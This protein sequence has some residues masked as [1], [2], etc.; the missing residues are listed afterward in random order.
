MYY[1]QYSMGQ[2]KRDVTPL[3]THWCYVFL[4]LTHQSVDYNIWRP[5]Q[6]GWYVVDNILKCILLKENVYISIQILLKFVP[7]GPIDNSI[8]SSNGLSPNNQQAIYWINEGSISSQIHLCVT[9]LNTLRPRQDGRLFG[10]WHLQMHFLEW[11]YINF[12]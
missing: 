5:E 12:E 3:L 9:R 7:E 6:N 1:L 2:C 10:R 11:I 4:A 8:C